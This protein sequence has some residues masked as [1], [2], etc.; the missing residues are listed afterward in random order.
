MAT[1]GL[2]S[3]APRDSLPPEPVNVAAASGALMMVRRDEFLSAGGFD[4]LLWMYGEEADYVLRTLG[5]GRVVLHPASAIRHKVGHASGPHQSPVRLY[6]PSRNR[7][8]NAARHLSGPALVRAVVSSAAFDLLTLVQ[9]RRAWALAA[10]GRGWRDGLRLMPRVRAE[11]TSAERVA[12]ARRLVG[13]RTAIAEQRRLGR[14]GV[15]AR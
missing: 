2:R 5:R 1:Y 14:A 6:W 15:T 13:L 11:R 3:G 4:E 7:L 12:A 10:V 9:V 8:I